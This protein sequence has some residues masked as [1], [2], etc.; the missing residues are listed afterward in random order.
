VQEVAG[1]VLFPVAGDELIDVLGRVGVDP[2]Q[3]IAPI[4]I[5]LAVYT[6]AK[7]SDAQLTLLGM[8]KQRWPSRSAAPV[9]AGL[10]H[11]DPL[12]A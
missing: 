12:T 11:L 7:L 4:G 1:E 5:G 8:G 9:P 10:G 3:D 6:A 2:L